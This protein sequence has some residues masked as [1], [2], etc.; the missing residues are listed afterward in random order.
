[1]L[2]PPAALLVAPAAIAATQPGATLG[3]AQAAI[4]PGVALQ[5]LLGLALVIAA[6]AVTAWIAR[7]MLALKPGVGGRMRVL[8]ALSVGGRERVV[9]VQVGDTQVVLGVAPGRVQALHVMATPLPTSEPASDTAPAFAS[10]LARLAG[11]RGEGA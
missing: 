2:V 9:L 5:L 10:V 1:M 11:G 3:G 7:R 8:G 4:G 6:I